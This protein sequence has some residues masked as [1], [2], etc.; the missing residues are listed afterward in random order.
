M[1]ADTGFG[2]LRKPPR[3]ALSDRGVL[4]QVS[5]VRSGGHVV[6][7]SAALL[8]D[9]RLETL[10]NLVDIPA[11][12]LLTSRANIDEIKLDVVL[13]RSDGAIYALANGGAGFVRDQREGADQPVCL[14]VTRG[15]GM[16]LN[17]FARD[18]RDGKL[19]CCY[20]DDDWP[21]YLYQAIGFGCRNKSFAD[22]ESSPWK[23][24]GF[25]TPE[26]SEV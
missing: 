11:S 13:T 3:F 20:H 15:N 26:I 14:T 2:S 25:E 12:T 1:Q 5:D 4:I 6:F 19:E 7:S 8:T 18:F 23:S 9:A 21:E 24:C 16:S 22:T 10:G 17:V